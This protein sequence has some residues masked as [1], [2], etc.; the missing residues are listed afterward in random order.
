MKMTMNKQTKNSNNKVKTVSLFGKD[1]EL[2]RLIDWT[3]LVVFI[4]VVIYLRTVG[5]Y[6]TVKIIV[7]RSQCNLPNDF[8]IQNISGL[9]P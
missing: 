5:T 8:I 9:V 6:D 2:M 4:L 3:L 1:F 7:D